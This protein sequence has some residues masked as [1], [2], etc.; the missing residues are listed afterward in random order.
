MLNKY[1]TSYVVD[2]WKYGSHI[3]AKSF[4]EAESIAVERNIGEKVIGISSGIK[5][6]FG[7]KVPEELANPDFVK[8]SDIGFVKQLPDIIHTACFLGYISS[9]SASRHIDILSDQGVLHELI[10]LMV[11]NNTDTRKIRRARGKFMQ[12]QNSILGYLKE[13]IINY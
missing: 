6:G 13:K 12:L 8:L 9:H 7:R 5:D 4:K 1:L 10:H 3:W 2:H 11:D